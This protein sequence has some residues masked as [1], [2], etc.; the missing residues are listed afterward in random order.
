MNILIFSGNWDNR[1]DESAIRAMIDEIQ[2]IYPKAKFK[3]QFNVP[4]NTLPYS[5]IQIVKSFYKPCGRNKLRLIPYYL[6]IFTGG[7]L[8]L[9]IGDNRKLFNEFIAAIKWADIALYAPGGPN[10]GDF[11]RQY[12]LVDMIHLMY[13]NKLPYIFY[14]PSMGPFK[15]Y[16]TRI[17]K[18]LQRA[19]LIC[20]RESI[21]ERYVKEL[22]EDIDVTV[23]LDSAF[24]HKIDENKYSLMLKNYTE[25]YEFLSRHKK[26]V[27]ITISDLKWHR[28]YKD[29]DIAKRIKVSFEKFIFNLINKG[30]AVIFIPQLFANACDKEYMSSFAIENCFTVDDQ[31]DCYFQQYLISKLYAVVGMRY[32]SNIFSAKMGTPFVSIAYEQKMKGFME[33]IQMMQYCIDINSLSYEELETKFEQLECN[34]E[35][36]KEALRS[37]MDARRAESFKTTELVIKT[38]NELHLDK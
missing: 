18:M 10:I 24:Q 4:V 32:H 26:V 23:T 25:L 6:T 2:S 29:S 35:Y 34:Y 30:Y 22:K 27:G 38:I 33:K 19:T 5:N 1:G 31:Y 8:N 37:K 20:L 13:L 3:M 15:K 7:K 16:K 17:I 14:A 36:Y 21:S 9:L 11:Y 12:V 28:L